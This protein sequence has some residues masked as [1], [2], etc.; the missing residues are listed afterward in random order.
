VSA[1]GGA[2]DSVRSALGVLRS[3]RIY[4]G[5]RARRRAMDALH[6]QFTERGD[7]VFDVGSHVGDRIASFR[8]LGCR[9]VAVEPQPHLARLLK[10]IYGWRRDVTIVQA[11][12]G[13]AEGTLDLHLNLANPTIATGSDA[14]IDAARGADGWRAERWTQRVAVPLTTLD[15]L[16]RAHG[17]PAFVKIDVEGF[18]ADVLAGLSRPLPAFSFEFTTIQRDV[19]LAALD[20][21]RALG[22]YAFNAALGES[23]RLVFRQWLAP[24]DLRDWLNTLPAAANSGDIYARLQP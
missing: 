16:I 21:S 9:V 3:L 19:A 14:F 6:A 24:A 15:A 13:A 7:L 8:R 12:V 23:Q 17:A 1:S 4:Y 18:E 11:A 10:L 2:F 22:R 5:G 20:R